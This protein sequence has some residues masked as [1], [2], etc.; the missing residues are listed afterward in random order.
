MVAAAAADSSSSSRGLG[1]VAHQQ[2]ARHKHQHAAAQAGLRVQ[3]ADVVLALLEGQRRQLAQDLQS[4]RAVGGWMG[5]QGSGCSKAVD[6]ARQRMQQGSGCV[7]QQ[8]RS[9]AGACAGAAESLQKG[10]GSRVWAAAASRRALPTA[11]ARWQPPWA[12]RWML[13]RY[14]TREP[15][16]RGK[17][18]RWAGQPGPQ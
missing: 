18:H 17:Q 13:H 12:Q 9:T 16:T 1:P 2:L 4:S 3:R 11:S 7:G 8:R 14:P 10:A 5:Q 15:S 6:A